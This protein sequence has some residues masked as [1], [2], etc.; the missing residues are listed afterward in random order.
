MLLRDWGKH[1]SANYFAVI[2][3]CAALR[4]GF[5]A[6]STFEQANRLY[7]QGKYAE[8]AALYENV[9]KGGRQSAPV[10]F[11]LGNA[12]FKDGKIGRA[13]YHYRIAERLKPRDPDIQA[14]LRFSRDRLPET[15]SRAP[16]AWNRSLN[17]FTVNELAVVF[18]VVFWAWAILFGLA[19]LRPGM[20]GRLRG[21][22]TG[23]G[24]VA[25]V[26]FVVL[27]V[28]DA[29]ARKLIAVSVSPQG[30]VHLGPLAESQV[31]FPAPD[32][33]ELEV[34]AERGEWLQ[35]VDRNGRTGW[36]AKTDQILFPPAAMR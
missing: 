26:M 25:G 6:E 18:S 36:M 29:S 17:Y 15:V 13:I 12:Y 3:L 5:A 10:F 1:V 28:A 9:A 35:V 4:S 30:K 27:L 8:A 19:R 21:F 20:A 32:G 2:F 22:I 34:L 31:A 16:T 23:S 14:N 11:N 24:V 7:E 33:S